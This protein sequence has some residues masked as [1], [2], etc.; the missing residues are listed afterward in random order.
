MNQD[1]TGESNLTQTPDIIESD[2]AWSPDGAR[3]HSS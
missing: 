1:G 3:S 2:P